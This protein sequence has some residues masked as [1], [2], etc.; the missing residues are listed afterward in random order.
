M[1]VSSSDSEGKGLEGAIHDGWANVIS[2]N[3]VETIG[4]RFG[5]E[6]H[7]AEDF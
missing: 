6:T 2:S 4:C 3:G 1:V 5:E 7:D